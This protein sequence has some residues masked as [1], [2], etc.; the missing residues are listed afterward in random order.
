MNNSGKIHT[1]SHPQY[2]GTT[3]IDEKKCTGCGT[4][5]KVCPSLVLKMENGKAFV[6]KPYYCLRCGHCGSVCPEGA[7]S[8]TSTEEISVYCLNGGWEYDEDLLQSH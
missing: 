4:C 8:E 3:I 5:V 1:E 7:I 6:D 2:T